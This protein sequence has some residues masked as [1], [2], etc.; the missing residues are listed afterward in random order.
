MQRLKDENQFVQKAAEQCL[1]TLSRLEEVQ[2]FSKK[3]VPSFSALYRSFCE[4]Q[5]ELGNLESLKVEEN[6][7]IIHGKSSN[8][9]ETSRSDKNAKNNQAQVEKISRQETLNKQALIER[10]EEIRRNS[11]TPRNPDILQK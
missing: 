7:R 6:Q 10:I 4:A 1:L 3:L 5:R 2:S 11:N 9:S 8:P